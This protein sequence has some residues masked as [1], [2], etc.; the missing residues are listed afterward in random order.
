VSTQKF[1][2]FIKDSGGCLVSRNIIDGRG[3]IK[4]VRRERSANPVDTGWRILS[5]IDTDDFLNE[6]GNLIVASFN[7]IAN[8]EPALIGIYN[9]PVGA[10]LQLVVQDGRRRRH[11][12]TTGQDLTDPLP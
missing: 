4:W 11:D 1:T 7:S 8:L 12:N 3:H 6:P 9:L 2:E 10:D 5:D